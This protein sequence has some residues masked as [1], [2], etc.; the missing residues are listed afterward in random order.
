[1]NHP[2]PRRHF[3]ATISARHILAIA[4]ATLAALAVLI[5]SA[6]AAPPRA[7]TTLAVPPIAPGAAYE[8]TNL[9]SDVAGIARI[10]DPQLVNP[11]GLT[12]RGTSPFWTANNGSS[13]S[14]VLQVVPATDATT[15]SPTLPHVAIPGGLPTGIVGNTTSDF[16]MGSAPANFLF[17]S[18]TGNITGW[19]AAMGGAAQIAVS[20]PGHVWTGLAIGSNSGGNRLYAADF[21]NNHIDVFNG[22]FALTTTTGGFIDATIPVGYA[23]FNIQNLGGALYV[24]YAKVGAGGESENGPGNGYVRKFNTDGVRDL[25]F[26]INNGVLDAPWGLAIAPASFG[27]FGN[28]LIVGNF[29]DAGRLNAYNPTTGAFLGTLQ[30]AGGNPIEIDELWALQFGNGGNAGDPNA[31]YFT[32]GIVEETH[33]L[34]GV[35]RPTTAQVTSLIRFTSSDY[36]ALESQGTV[37]ITVLRDGDVSGAATVRY[38]PLT[39]AGTGFADSSDFTLAPNTL[40]FAPGESLKT[41][42]VGIT[43]DAVAEGNETLQLVLSN[44]TGASLESPSIATLTILEPTVPAIAPGSAYVQTNLASDVAGIAQIVDP[45]LVNPW[46]LTFR[47]TSPFW[48]ANNGS[49]SSSLL[50]VVPATDA[51]TLNPTLPHVAIP[52]GLPT[53]TV[54]N[55]TSDFVMGSA[56]ANFLFA[57][58]TG[59]LTGWN[60]AMGAA[61][62]IA[63]SMPGHVFTGLAIGSNS[64][65]NRLYAADFANNHIDVFNGTFAPTTTT[66]GFIDATI[67]AG[68][69][70]FNI[71]NL[72]GA[73]YVT[74]AKVGVDGESENGPGN[75][76]VRKFNTD[77]VRD[78]TFAINNGVLD[79]PW[80]LAIAPAS[81]GIFGNALIVGNF[82][83]DGR[84][85]AYNPT[86]GA[87]LGTLQDAG[88]NPIEIDELWA[89][90]FGNGGNGGDTNALYF[91]AGIVEETH[92]LF[93]VLRP[94]TAQATSLIRFITDNVAAPETAGSINVTVIREGNATGIATVHYAALTGSG[95]GFADSSDFTL[96]PNTLTFASG[97]VVKTFT[98]GITNDVVAEGDE[99]LQLVLSNPT[100]AQLSAPSIATLTILDNGTGVANLTITK[101]APSSA[102]PNSTFNYTITVANQGP[103]AAT[104]VVVTDNLP[105]G[106]SFV[107][108]TPSQGSC[109]GT[110]AITCSLGTLNSGANATITLTVHA[111]ASDAS[112]SNTASVTSAQS[113]PNMTNNAAT[114]VVQV[115]SPVPVPTLSETVLILMALLLAAVAAMR[116]TR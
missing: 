9:A 90:Q 116:L 58:I 45:Q 98:V 62:Q 95:A 37:T 40:T 17:A 115:A 13:S 35:L 19:N 81:F 47:G 70:P 1:M 12:Y 106:L 71:Q 48:T 63:V 57:S 108:A 10:V 38:A 100:G 111:P 72:G 97:E 105:A 53:G 4:L 68:Y 92:G 34:F 26:A 65:G 64:G 14:S 22:T 113:D 73:L 114:A 3:A 96:A 32:A 88:G 27:I 41:F 93:G 36:A 112:L 76:Y 42:T 39:G 69:A 109:T 54:G 43:N 75:G 91:T 110:T 80:G 59:N 89:L 5:P 52:G 78:L 102:L 30:D 50:Q 82:S 74:Y 77:G 55:A 83:D 28:A 44:P 49:S 24:T 29:A 84:L 99:T 33:G 20:M 16:V 104:N 21:A 87:F 2:F 107:S 86:T 31:L 25:T 23:P 94:T 46:G 85:H 66:G 67:P 56:P 6:L 60:A 15:L 8:Q 103:D 79:A 7:T 61:A 101:T 51:T 11:W 18:I